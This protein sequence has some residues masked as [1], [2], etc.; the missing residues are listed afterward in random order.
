MTGSLTKKHRMVRGLIKFN[1][2]YEHGDL[3]RQQLLRAMII[4]YHRHRAFI[5]KNI[6]FE[7]I[8]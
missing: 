7:E 6:Q 5:E 1:E 8:E 2:N 4:F 3:L